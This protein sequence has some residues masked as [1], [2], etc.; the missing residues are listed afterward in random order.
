[1]LK[2]DIERRGQT[3]AVLP[4]PAYGSW[5]KDLVLHELM[6]S[7]RALSSKMFTNLRPIWHKNSLNQTCIPVYVA[8]FPPDVL[9]IVIRQTDESNVPLEPL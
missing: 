4:P 6:N 2:W 8:N 9:P 3:R 1:M 5:V 7:M